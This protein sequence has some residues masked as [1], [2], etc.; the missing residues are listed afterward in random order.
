V[1]ICFSLNYLI[2]ERFK[3]LVREKGIGEPNMSIETSDRP[4]L[5]FGQLHIAAPADY[6]DLLVVECD[7]NMVLYIRDI[8]IGTNWTGMTD[9]LPFINITLNGRPYIKDAYMFTN[10]VAFG[11]GGHLK[12]WNHR[13]PIVIQA[14][15]N[16]AVATD[17]AAY[18]VGTEVEQF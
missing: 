1:D 18:V 9:P 14:K 15:I 11:F 17:L 3:R 12:M 2:L 16:V 13:K 10:A 8:F 5:K 4:L 6:Q 7:P